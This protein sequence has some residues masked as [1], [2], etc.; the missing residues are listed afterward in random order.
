MHY[1]IEEEGEN[2]AKIKSMKDWYF[3]KLLVIFVENLERK[4]STFPKFNF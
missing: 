3:K 4:I 1:E 2:G